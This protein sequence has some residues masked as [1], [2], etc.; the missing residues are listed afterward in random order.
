MQFDFLV[1]FSN[2]TNNINWINNP[3]N[4]KKIVL[5]NLFELKLTNLCLAKIVLELTKI[6][7][8]QVEFN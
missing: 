1:L 3:Y 8:I 6:G 2:W 5:N 7:Y 4:K